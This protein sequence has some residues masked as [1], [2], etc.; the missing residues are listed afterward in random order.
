MSRPARKLTLWESIDPDHHK[1]AAQGYPTRHFSPHVDF[2]FQ[3]SLLYT[4]IPLKR[5]VSDLISLCG[6]RRLIWVDTLRNGHN[7]DFLSGSLTSVIRNI[8]GPLK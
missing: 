3:E 5:N 1:Q 8:Y 4:S 7:V 6:L 2:Q